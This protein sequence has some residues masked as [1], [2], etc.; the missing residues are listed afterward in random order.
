MLHCALSALVSAQTVLITLLCVV[1]AELWVCA[2]GQ[3]GPV[4]GKSHHHDGVGQEE[5]AGWTGPGCKQTSV[6][7]ICFFFWRSMVQY[8]RYL[9]IYEENTSY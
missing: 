3:D 2:Q 8:A 5:A 6:V 7:H 9:F 1:V 4:G